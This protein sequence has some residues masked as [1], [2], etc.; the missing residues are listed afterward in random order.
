MRVLCKLLHRYILGPQT[1][2]ILHAML[3]HSLLLWLESSK[4]EALLTMVFCCMKLSPYEK[5]CKNVELCNFHKA[6][7]IRSLVKVNWQ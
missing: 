7:E 2:T 1:D 4:L 6:I 3:S 5:Y